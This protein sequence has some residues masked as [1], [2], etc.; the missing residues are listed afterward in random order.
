[1]KIL[2]SPTLDALLFVGPPLF[3]WAM[4]SVGFHIDYDSVIPEVAA[5]VLTGFLLGLFNRPERAWIWLLGLA[6]GFVL[7][8]LL[9][10]RIVTM[11]NGTPSPEHIARYGPPRTSAAPIYD[12][13]RLWAFPAG[14]SVVGMVCRAVCR[15]PW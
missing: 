9:P 13:W 1:M 10:A 14:G 8:P 7:M 15:A 12:A 4:M 6:V 11:I 3:I 5:M 2:Q